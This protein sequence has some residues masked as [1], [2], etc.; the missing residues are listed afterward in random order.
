MAN[1]ILYFKTTVA[2]HIILQ[3]VPN[4]ANGDSLAV[5]ITKVSA[6]DTYLAINFHI[7]GHL[8]EQAQNSTNKLPLIFTAD[9][10]ALIDPAV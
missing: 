7:S 3:Y 1:V 6:T 9:R 4:R 8:G 10:L 2:Q 5:G